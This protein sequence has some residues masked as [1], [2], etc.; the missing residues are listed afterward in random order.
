MEWGK[1]MGKGMNKNKAYAT[2]ATM[3]P[4]SL[5]ELIQKQTCLMGV[6]IVSVGP[7]MNEHGP[8]TQI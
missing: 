8:A 1:S 3:K 6:K 5:S 7:K 2:Y 4:V